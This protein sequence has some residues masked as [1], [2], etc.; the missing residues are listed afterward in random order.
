MVD[1]PTRKNNIV[2]ILITNCPIL[3][4]KCIP[5]PGLGYHDIVLISD[6]IVPSRHKPTRRLIV[7]QGQQIVRLGTLQESSE[8]H[9][10]VHY[11]FV[12]TM[13]S[14]GGNKKKLYTFVKNM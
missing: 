10:K 8:D 14:Y 2:D 13:V 5:I 6:Y 7:Q 11:N 3:V 1:L 4:N 12:N 9:K